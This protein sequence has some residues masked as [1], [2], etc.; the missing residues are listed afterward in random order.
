MSG[1]GSAHPKPAH[2]E[3]V[4]GRKRILAIQDEASLKKLVKLAA[5][6]DTLDAFVSAVPA[7][8]KPK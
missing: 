6:C 3:P 7:R 1:T 8:R 4:E 2:P 5:T